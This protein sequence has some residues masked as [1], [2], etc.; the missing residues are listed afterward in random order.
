MKIILS[1]VVALSS[2]PAI[3]QKPTEVL[4]TTAGRTFTARDLSPA[5]QN[6]IEKLPSM[7]ANLRKQLLAQ[8]LGSVLLETEAKTRNMQIPAL[9]KLETA[10]VKDPT[11]AEIQAVY[12]ANKAAIGNKSLA[13]VRKQIVEFI[14]HDPEEKAVMAFIDSLAAKHK[15]VYGKDVNAPDLKPADVLFT[16]GGR[17]VAAREFEEETKM[18]LYGARYDFYEDLKAEVEDAVHNAL[19]IEEAKAQ[20]L[21]PG[22]L[23]AREVTSKMKD[24]S[25]A[26]RTGLESAFRARLFS[27]YGARILLTEPE[28]V[29]QNISVDDDPSRGPA[30]AHVTIVMFSDFQCS[31]CA[32]THPILKSVMGEYGDKVRLVVRD[33]PLESIHE[34]AFKAALAAGAA[35]AQGKFFEYTEMLYKHQDALDAES[36]KKY[37]VEAGLNVKQFELDF[38]SEKVAAEV[39]KDQAEGQ[40]YGISGTPAIFVNGVGV[41]TLSAEAFRKA[42]DRAL[43]K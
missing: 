3:A 31:A 8:K 16:V 43:K 30:A 29:V 40:T 10:K 35:N 41:R 25:D 42:I 18:A 33:F 34:N 38:S 21:E 19:A 24:Y 1:I 9:L 7:I 2:Y 32:A 23:I 20:K 39:R 28:P 12:D 36:L 13:E 11:P 6:A 37:A 14:R 5:A 17:S 26:E 15:V 4:A 27:K 22:D